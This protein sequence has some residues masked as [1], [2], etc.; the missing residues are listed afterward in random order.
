MLDREGFRHHRSNTLE[1]GKPREGHQQV[2]E[3]WEQQS[4]RFEGEL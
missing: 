3:Q 1:T 2:A 4:H